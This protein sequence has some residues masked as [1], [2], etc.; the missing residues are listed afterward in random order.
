MERPAKLDIPEKIDWL[1]KTGQNLRPKK[2]SQYQQD[3]KN[4][5]ENNDKIKKFFEKHPQITAL[6]N[7]DQT[8]LNLNASYLKTLPEVEKESK[9]SYQYRN[10]P[11]LYQQQ[12][13]Y[14]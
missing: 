1:D 9:N 4:I 14:Q 6:M 13:Y 11:N 12:A 7:I 2:T 10:H 5:L 8:N 3:L